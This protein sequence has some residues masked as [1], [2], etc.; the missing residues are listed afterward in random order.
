M[1]DVSEPV[2]IRT[3]ACPLCGAFP[4]MV[5]GH[6]SQAFCPTDDCQVFTWNPRLGPDQIADA[7]FLDI[8]ER[9]DP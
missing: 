3:P 7:A 5:L 1:A 8:H 6:A 2:V 9:T 4:A